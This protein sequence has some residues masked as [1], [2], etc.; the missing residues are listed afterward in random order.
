[1]QFLCRVE[2]GFCCGF[3]AS[4][5]WPFSAFSLHSDDSSSD[6]SDDAY[7][8]DGSQW[9][10]TL[11]SRDAYHYFLDIP[12]IMV[13]PYLRETY[14]ALQVEML[15]LYFTHLLVYVMHAIA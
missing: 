2:L 8:G 6:E 12:G 3:V 15:V 10:M 4:Y 14:Q 7:G 11:T 1:M 13:A 5:L 9:W